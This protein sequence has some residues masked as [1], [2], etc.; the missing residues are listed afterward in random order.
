MWS[1]NYSDKAEKI[2]KTEIISLEKHADFAER[3][4]SIIEQTTNL[5]VEVG[6]AG[7]SKKHTQHILKKLTAGKELIS[8][9]RWDLENDMLKTFPEAPL[10]T[11]YRKYRGEKG[12]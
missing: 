10:Y 5:L 7:G 3:I 9:A 1:I 2:M 11:Q 6:R 4:N 12:V 8:N